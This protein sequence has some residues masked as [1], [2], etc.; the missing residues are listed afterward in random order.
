MGQAT[1]FWSN[2][3]DNSIN[4]SNSSR[5]TDINI[6]LILSMMEGGEGAAD[7]LVTPRKTKKKKHIKRR[8]LR[9]GEGGGVRPFF[10]SK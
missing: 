1:V 10:V 4:N 6:S 5:N 8:Q 9:G 2:D 7:C 3:N